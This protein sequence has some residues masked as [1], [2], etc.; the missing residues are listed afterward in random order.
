MS[1]QDETSSD[2]W[3]SHCVWIVALWASFFN[4]LN[5]NGYPLFRPEVAITML[6]LAL[7]GGVMALIQ[8]AAKP[9]LWFLVVALFAAV[10][11]D[12]NASISAIWFLGCWA[13]FA[14]IAFYVREVFVKILFAAAAAVLFFQGAELVLDDGSPREAGNEVQN[15]QDPADH[16]R[17]F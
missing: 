13:I 14:V 6:A 11:V 4:L 9:R 5:F 17:K 2:R 10:L 16:K 1:I 3:L 7:V 12:L 8:Q 15:L